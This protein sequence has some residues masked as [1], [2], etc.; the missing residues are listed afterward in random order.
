M[1]IPEI[2]KL[3]TSNASLRNVLPFARPLDASQ[4]LC[5]VKQHMLVVCR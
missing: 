3:R 4:A 5:K 1:Y 2:L